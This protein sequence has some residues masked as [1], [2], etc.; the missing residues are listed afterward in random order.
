MKKEI[1]WKGGGKRNE[2]FWYFEKKK[3]RERREIR[4]GAALHDLKPLPSHFHFQSIPCHPTPSPIQFLAFK[5]VWKRSQ[6]KV[7][8]L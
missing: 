2:C 3:K 5:P 7:F 8:D 4:N 1:H 6:K